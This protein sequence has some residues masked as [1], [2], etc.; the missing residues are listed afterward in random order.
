MLDVAAG[1]HPEVTTQRVSLQDLAASDL[2][3][4]DAVLCIDAMENIGPEDRPRVVA[5]MRHASVAGG[6]AYVTVELPDDSDERDLSDAP[7]VAGEV[8]SDGAYHYYPAVPEAAATLRA[9]GFD[10]EAS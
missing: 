4:F 8:L 5:G 7:L 3:G 1:K 2:A 9:V 6:T 10:I